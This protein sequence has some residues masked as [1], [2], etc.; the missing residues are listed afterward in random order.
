MIL[1]VALFFL[2]CCLGINAE[3]AASV[4]IVLYALYFLLGPKD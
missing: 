2:L 4:A 3:V 1:F